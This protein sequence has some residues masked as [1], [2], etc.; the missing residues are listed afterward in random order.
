VAPGTVNTS[1]NP[2]APTPDGVEQPVLD[3]AARDALAKAPDWSKDWTDAER[4][5]FTDKGKPDPNGIFKMYMNAE[6]VMTSTQR[7]TLPKEGDEA[8]I[9]LFNKASA[10]PR[11]RKATRSTSRRSTAILSS[12]NHS[13]ALHMLQV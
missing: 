3:Q 2:G 10:F 9:K 13:R 1:P 12:L 5:F 6:R 7:V 8:S 11:A 4:K